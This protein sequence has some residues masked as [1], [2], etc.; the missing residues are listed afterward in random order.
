M[1]PIQNS[2]RCIMVHRQSGVT[3]L[4]DLA[5][6]KRFTLAIN[7]G[8]PFAQ[9]LKKKVNL[10]D[11]Q[12]VNYG[13]NVA[14]FL[15][16]LNYGQQAYSFSEPYVV[17]QQHGHP[18]CLML[19][20]IGFNAYTSALFTRRELI[21]KQPE[22]VAKITRASIRGWAKYLAEPEPTNRYIHEQNSEMK[23]EILAFGAETLRP[24]CVP[25]GFDANRLGEMTTERWQLLIS[26]MTEI[27]LL[28]PNSMSPADAFT[29]KFIGTK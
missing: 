3:R 10:D 19:S 16:D 2:P 5:S 27:G 28:K 22:L 26:Q 1:S 18:V 4:E 14:P 17:Q 6:K 8:Q 9:F 11:V 12:I 25:E 20:D 21:E 29:V 7:T 23:P 15:E 24:L 13:G